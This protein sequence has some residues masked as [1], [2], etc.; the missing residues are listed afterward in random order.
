MACPPRPPAPLGGEARSG[1]T[2]GLGL[3]TSPNP[4]CPDRRVKVWNRSPCP[5]PTFPFSEGDH[6]RHQIRDIHQLPCE[7]LG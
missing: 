4:A 6:G 2:Q 5:E 3:L 7:E 1:R